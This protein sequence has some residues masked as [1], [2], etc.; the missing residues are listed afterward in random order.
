MEKNNNLLYSQIFGNW[1][2]LLEDAGC[3]DLLDQIL[4]ALDVL[5]E[6]KTIYPIRENVF[7][8]F[9]SN[10][11]DIKV[12][13]LGQDPYPGVHRMK[14]KNSEGGISFG[15]PVPDACGYSFITENGYS[16]PSLVNLFIEL[17][18]DDNTHRIPGYWNYSDKVDI[19]PFKKWVEQGVLMLNAALTVE[20]GCS[21]SHLLMWR[22]FSSRLIKFLVSARP[23][24]VWILLGNK[25][26]DLLK[27]YNCR[28]IEA[29]HPSPL[30]GGKFFGSKIYSRTN[31]LLTNPIKW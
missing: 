21:G 30:A 24:L 15:K 22:E 26:Q 16:P 20:A 10:P 29:A 19:Y 6:N 31:E 14:Y 4:P 11:D 17:T 12:V 23:D 27:G 25:A 8:V 13:F 3:L 5:Y 28:K 1:F 18:N 2:E 9:K 7:R